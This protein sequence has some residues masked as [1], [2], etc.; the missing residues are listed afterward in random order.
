MGNYAIPNDLNDILFDD[1]LVLR[2]DSIFLM[3]FSPH[4]G[5]KPRLLAYSIGNLVIFLKE[6]SN[7]FSVPLD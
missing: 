5:W 6:Q 3:V 7:T 2:L 1:K 4:P